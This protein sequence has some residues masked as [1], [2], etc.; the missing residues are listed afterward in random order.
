MMQRLIKALMTKKLMVQ[1]GRNVQGSV[2]IFFPNPKVQD[3]VLTD[4]RPVDVY[5]RINISDD[6]IKESNL[7]AL[8]L[9]GMIVILNG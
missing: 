6:D 1:K 9:K 5:G 8:A 7:E 2:K 3:I 4:F